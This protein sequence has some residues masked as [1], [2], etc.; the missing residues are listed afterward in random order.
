M[1]SRKKAPPPNPLVEAGMLLTGFVE[2]QLVGRNASRTT[3]LKVTAKVRELLKNAAAGGCIAVEPHRYSAIKEA[4]D[5]LERQALDADADVTPERWMFDALV[6]NH[7]GGPTDVRL[8]GGTI[9]NK[10]SAKENFLRAAC[11]VLWEDQPFGR[12][13]LVKDAR[14]FLGVKNQEAL[15]RI[16]DNHHQRH[17]ADLEKTKSPLSVHIPVVKRLMEANGWCALRDFAP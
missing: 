11:V 2:H 9:K 6:E 12:D 16:V 14:R 13:Q 4:C 3:T 17:D 5:S 1:S 10:K 7:Q 8:G 15:R